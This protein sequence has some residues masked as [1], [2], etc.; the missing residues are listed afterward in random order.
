M[1]QLRFKYA[2]VTAYPIWSAFYNIYLHPLR[3]YPG[4]KLAVVSKA[5]YYYWTLSGKLHSKIKEV[6]DQYGDVVRFGPNT[7]LYR[8]PTGWK[9]IYSHRDAG[10]DSFVKDPELYIQGPAGPSILNANDADHSRMRR[11]LSHA[12]SD[13]ALREQ[14]PLLQSYVD[15]LVK[16]LQGHVDSSSNSVDM[17]KWYN[18]TTFDIIGDLSFGESFDC[19]KNSDYH[20]WVTAVFQSAK[21]GVFMRPLV[22]LLPLWLVGKM[23]PAKVKQ[24]RN[25]H[26]LMSKDKVDRRLRVKSSRPDFMTYILK[27]GDGKG[28]NQNEIESNGAILILAGSETTASL[29][30]GLTFYILKNERTYKRLVDEI[31]GSFQSE[32]EI[33][34]A[35][36]SALP[37]LHAV[38]AESLRMYPPVP[39]IITRIVPDGGSIIDDK[40]VPGGTVVSMAFFSAFHSKDNFAEPDSFIPE[41]WLDGID[42]KFAFDNRDV[43]QP[44]SIG[45]RNCLG[46]NLAY[47]E[48][49]LI[50]T[51]LLWNFDMTLEKD[52]YAWDDQRSFI[53]WEKP[54]LMVNLTSHDTLLSR[55]SC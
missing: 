55:A 6:H 14:E 42:P 27:H 48:M 51:K 7:L 25:H 40:F 45:P 35:S 2:K 41:R 49:G 36:A 31:R 1:D 53:I 29:L 10:A 30:C 46:R 5:Y 15:L 33:N 44:F 50:V 22:A 11:L 28:M 16:R 4:P 18:Y 26:Y 43:M 24:M 37:Y 47:A 54:P 3:I 52:S 23:I 13:K 19:L 34:V 38:V 20:P 32:E 8:S 39:G 17:T 9:D 21:V 12:L